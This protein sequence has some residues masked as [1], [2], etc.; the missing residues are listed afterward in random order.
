M[1][2]NDL[3]KA[4]MEAM[5]SRDKITVGA[6]ELVISKLMLLTI[7]KRAK[8][9]T[10]SES[11]NVAVLQKAIKQLDEEKIGFE[12]AGRT[13]KTEILKKQIEILSALL[14]K[15]LSRDEI[16]EIINGLE[17]RSM[18]TVMKYFKSNYSGKCNMKDV[19][20]VMKSF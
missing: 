11:D 3:K 7:D 9:E 5:K 19:S 16:I 13:E 20:D 2:I 14:P 6:L 4:K 17:D 12:Q 15:M 18:P 10:V 8:G 1:D